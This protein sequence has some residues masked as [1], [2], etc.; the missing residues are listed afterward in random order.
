MTEEQA[1]QL[2]ASTARIERMLA[3][4]CDTFKQPVEPPNIRPSMVRYDWDGPRPVI[5]SQRG[6]FW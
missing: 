5:S 6:N 3:A 1:A 4:L 2:I